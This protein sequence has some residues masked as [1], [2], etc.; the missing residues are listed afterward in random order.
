LGLQLALER[1]DFRV[2]ECR[3]I[4]TDMESLLN[5]RRRASRAKSISHSRDFVMRFLGEICAPRA[6]AFGRWIWAVGE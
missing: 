5:I 4:D 3:V 1:V 2:V 6:P